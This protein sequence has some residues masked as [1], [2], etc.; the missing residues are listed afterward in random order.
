MTATHDISVTSEVSDIEMNNS[1]FKNITQRKE[2][3]YRS[4]FDLFVIIIIMIIYCISISSIAGN[5]DKCKS[6]VASQQPQ[7]FNLCDYSITIFPV[8]VLSITI[9][10]YV[11]LHFL[12]YKCYDK[13]K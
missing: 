2:N 12:Y 4:I 13:N 10:V 1:K 7:L 11:F 6:V 5:L 3:I 9:S 8:I